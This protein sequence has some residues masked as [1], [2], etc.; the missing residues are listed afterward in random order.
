MPRSFVQSFFSIFC[1]A[2]AVDAVAFVYLNV[3][4]VAQFTLHCSSTQP[5]GG[6]DSEGM[7]QNETR[8]NNNN[9]KTSNVNKKPDSQTFNRW[10]RSVIY[11]SSETAEKISINHKNSRSHKYIL[12]HTLINCKE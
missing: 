2:H 6:K 1:A 9:E 11:A 4:W 3:C 8:R 5:N 12:T 7:R 10:F